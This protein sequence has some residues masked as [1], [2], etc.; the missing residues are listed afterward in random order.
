MADW[1][2]SLKDYNAE[3]YSVQDV[4]TIFIYSI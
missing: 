4:Q 1:K 3:L 2:M